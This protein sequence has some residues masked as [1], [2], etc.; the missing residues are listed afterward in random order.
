MYA[1]IYLCGAIQNRTD[2]Q[3]VAWRETVQ[4]KYRGHCSN[5]MRRDYRG[6]E[7]TNYR[8]LVEDDLNDIRRCDALLVYYDG[9]SV[10]TSMEIFYA[11][12]ILRMPVIVIDVSHVNR[13]PW[14]V[15]HTDIFTSTIDEAIAVLEQITPHK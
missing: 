10:G 7:L 11:H 1:S 15:R 3:C 6:R 12:R 13:S 9:P 5:P 14:L 2:E 8:Q 4:K